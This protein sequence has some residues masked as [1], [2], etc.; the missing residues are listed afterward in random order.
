MKKFLQEALF[1]HKW[2]L[3]P[4]CVCLVIAFGIYSLDFLIDLYLYVI[5]YHHRAGSE[6]V[7]LTLEFV[8]LLMVAFLIKMVITGGYQVFIDKVKENTERVSS[9]VLK[10]KMGTSLIGITSIHLLETF[11]IPPK[12]NREIIIKVGV[13]IVFL[14]SAYKL[15]Q[16]NLLDSEAE[17]ANANAEYIEAKTELLKEKLKEKEHE[18]QD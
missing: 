2:M 16:I 17:L 3:Y 4:L 18:K 13:H 10:V 12:D 8:D 15:A 7:L 9:G 14:Y 5:N 6:S 11:I 1:A